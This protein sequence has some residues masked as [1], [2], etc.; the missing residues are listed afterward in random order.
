MKPLEARLGR[1]PNAEESFE[2]LHARLE[3]LEKRV[4]TLES[5]P[6]ATHRDIKPKGQ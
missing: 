6:G 1:A 2:D 4:K 3:A 5:Q